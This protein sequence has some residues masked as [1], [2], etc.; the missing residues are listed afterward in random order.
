MES[1]MKA[2]LMEEVTKLEPQVSEKIVNY[3]KLEP[4]EKGEKVTYFGSI[5]FEN[6]SYAR[7]NFS[8]T[9]GWIHR[10]KIGIV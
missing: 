6:S 2:I 4:L 10:P 8:R 3:G 7:F 5:E 9:G 1:Q